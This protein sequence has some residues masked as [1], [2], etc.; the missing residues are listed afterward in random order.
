M[1]IQ[2][3]SQDANFQFI[4]S[5]LQLIILFPMFKHFNLQQPTF[6]KTYFFLLIFCFLFI[7]IYNYFLINF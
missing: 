5:N 6:K 2:Y 3:D 1:T 7:E 4:H